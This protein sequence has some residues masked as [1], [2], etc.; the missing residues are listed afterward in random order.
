VAATAKKKGLFKRQDIMR[1]VVL[2]TVPC[3]AIGV[4][5]FGWRVL[6]I[7]VV[8][9]ATGV[10]CEYLLARRRGDQVSEAVLVTALLFAVIMPPTIPWHVVVFGMAFSVVLSKEVFGGFG[11]NFFNPAMAGRCFV[12]IAFPVAM[13]AAWAPPAPSFLGNL[14]AWIAGGFEGSLAFDHLQGALG[15]W[16]T[17][18]LDTITGASPMGAA[19][20][21]EPVPPMSQLL[22]G[23]LSGVLGGTSALVILLGGL[24]LYIKKVANRS[25]ILSC[26]LTYFALNQVLHMLGV[27]QVRTNGFQAVCGGGFLFGAFYMATDPVSGPKTGPGRVIY[28]MLIATLTTTIRNFSIFNGGFMFSLLLANMFAPIIDYSVTEWKKMRAARGAAA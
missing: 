17:Y 4:Y 9:V 13:T 8:A 21:G 28:G 12:Y 2:A 14:Q 19:K 16:R 24:Y 27:P 10:I 26:V 25:I 3:I 1:K 18:T 7:A 6:A 15:Q 22:V 20:L 5:F 23:N 11:R